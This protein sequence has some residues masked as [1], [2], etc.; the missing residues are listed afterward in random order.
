MQPHSDSNSFRWPLLGT[1]VRHTVPNYYKRRLCIFTPSKPHPAYN[2]AFIDVSLP[3]KCIWLTRSSSRNPSSSSAHFGEQMRARIG[4]VYIVYERNYSQGFAPARD[5]SP[6]SLALV[7]SWLNDMLA[8]GRTFAYDNSAY[9]AGPENL[10]TWSLRHRV[11]GCVWVHVIAPT[12]C[13]ICWWHNNMGIKCSADVMLSLH[14]F[15]GCSLKLAGL[16]CRCGRGRSMDEKWF[17]LV[18]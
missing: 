16:P 18:G 5:I 2:T 4:T 13:M 3:A 15:V 9:P 12:T 17:N 10:R 7:N 1:Y 6:F 11:C 14:G 8:H